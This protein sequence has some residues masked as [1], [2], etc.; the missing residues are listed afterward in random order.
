MYYY[1]YFI[2]VYVCFACMYVCAP[3]VCLVPTEVRGSH[4]IPENWSYRWLCAASI[5]K[6]TSSITNPDF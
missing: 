1:Y 2:C 5:L 6:L 4:E 3:H